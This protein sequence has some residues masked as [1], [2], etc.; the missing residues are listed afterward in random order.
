M[1]NV[2]SCLL[3]NVCSLVTMRESFR[4]ETDLSGGNLVRQNLG[5]YMQFINLLE[6]LLLAPKPPILMDDA[7]G[8]R[9]RWKKIIEISVSIWRDKRVRYDSLWLCL[10]QISKTGEGSHAG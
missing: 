10:P 3:V 2:S 7:E 4:D 6:A 1:H 5:D 8:A 9:M